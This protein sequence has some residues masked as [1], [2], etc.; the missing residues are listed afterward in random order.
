[1]KSIGHEKSLAL[2]PNRQHVCRE[3]VPEIFQE[4]I[5]RDKSC[6]DSCACARRRGQVQM[7]QVQ[8]KL[9]GKSQEFILRRTQRPR[10]ENK[11]KGLQGRGGPG[12][13]ELGDKCRH[14]ET[15]LKDYKRHAAQAGRQM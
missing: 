15:N 1:M 2:S 7:S 9:E 5:G 8:Q 6:S 4:E 10:A 13:A 11:C 14:R 3:V 12:S